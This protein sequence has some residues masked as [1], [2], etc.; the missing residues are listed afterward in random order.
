MASR[1]SA[2][3]KI[4]RDLHP[5]GSGTPPHLKI[6]QHHVPLASNIAIV[7]YNKGNRC[8]VPAHI[9]L[10]VPI[11]PGGRL[12]RRVAVGLNGVA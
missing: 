3:P 11:V 6:V 4:K 9:V 8:Y 2:V 7:K 5:V 1:S 10:I 12:Q